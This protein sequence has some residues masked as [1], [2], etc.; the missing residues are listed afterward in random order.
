MCGSIASSAVPQ[1]CLWPE[2]TEVIV[3]SPLPVSHCVFCSGI[4]R[5]DV[6]EV[7]SSIGATTPFDLSQKR[8]QTKPKPFPLKSFLS[9]V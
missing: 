5:S 7:V 2:S 9:N 4:P 6:H 1:C 3:I 8:S